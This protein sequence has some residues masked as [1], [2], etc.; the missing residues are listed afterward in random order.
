MVGQW[1]LVCYSVGP[2]PCFAGCGTRLPF[3]VMFMSFIHSISGVC[4]HCKDSIPGCTGGDNCPTIVDVNSNAQIFSS[5]AIGSI[6]KTCHLLPPAL[7]QHFPRTVMEMIV[8]TACA[9]VGDQVIDFTST[10]GGWYAAFPS[11][12]EFCRRCPSGHGGPW[13]CP[14]ILEYLLH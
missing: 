6:P 9:P 1:D 7:M 14:K 12:R 10:A 4:I 11:P 8:A 2:S 5:N 3:F 13:H